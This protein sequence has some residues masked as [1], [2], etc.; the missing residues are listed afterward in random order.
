MWITL[1]LEEVVHG[2][3]RNTEFGRGRG[4]W[5]AREEDFS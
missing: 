5:L 2:M 3:G 4:N 1:Y